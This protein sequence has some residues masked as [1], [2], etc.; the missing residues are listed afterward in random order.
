MTKYFIV[1]CLEFSSI[2]KT[3][4][5]VMYLFTYISS[6]ENPPKIPEMPWDR[7]NLGETSHVHLIIRCPWSFLNQ[8]GL[9][10][11][12]ICHIKRK[13]PWGHC[14]SSEWRLCISWTRWYWPLGR[15]GFLLCKQWEDFRRLGFVGCTL[16]GINLFFHIRRILLWLDCAHVSGSSIALFPTWFFSLTDCGTLT[17]ISPMGTR[18]SCFSIGVTLNIF[19]ECAS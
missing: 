17:A 8:P 14:C 4:F 6:L 12:L 9:Y 18:P 16:F 3:I 11:F 5:N 1:T 19:L 2:P 13:S 10:R 15:W 7:P